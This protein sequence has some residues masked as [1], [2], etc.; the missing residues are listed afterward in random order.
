[1]SLAL[2]AAFALSSAATVPSCSWDKPGHD[3]FMGNVVEA[4]ER[5]TNIPLE[6]RDRLKKRMAA[7]QYD[8]IVTIR[9]DSITGH[10]R[11]SADIR[12]MHFGNGR[13]CRTVTRAAWAP[14]AVERGLV[15]CEG[16]HCIVVPT[17]CRNVSRITRLPP[18]TAGPGGPALPKGLPG[19]SALPGADGVAPSSKAVAL[20]SSAKPEAGELIFEPPAAG[21]GAMDPAQAAIQSALASLASANALGLSGTGG[22]AG[23][24]GG[25][26]PLINFNPYGGTASG[27]GGSFAP[28]TPSAPSEPA[29]PSTPGAVPPAAP[30]VAI[31]PPSLVPPL[32][33]LAPLPLVPPLVPPLLPPLIPPLVPPLVP[34]LSPPL[35]ELLPPLIAPSVP[36]PGTWLL[37]AAGLAALGALQRRRRRPAA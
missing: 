8:E 12:D 30:G 16:E 20:A 25:F 17:V 6:A 32:T 4:V 27:G 9:R 11:Y 34:P 28:V 35:E 19:G 10:H 21:G 33:P 26:A 18:Q 24:P 23:G 29:A 7:R 36:E 3:P 37:L 1:M 5:Y 22:G 13:V 14:T 31:D 2:A 15:Y